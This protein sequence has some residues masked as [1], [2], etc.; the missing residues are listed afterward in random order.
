MHHIE[1][2]QN[3][4]GKKSD[5]KVYMLELACSSMQRPSMHK[6]LDSISK[7]HMCVCAHTNA[8]TQKHT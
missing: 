1:E 6:G 3:Y 4:E 2:S 5:A 7:H 8:H